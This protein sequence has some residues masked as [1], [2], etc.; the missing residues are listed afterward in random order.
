MLSQQEKV[1]FFHF[2]VGN[3]ELRL[4]EGQDFL[5]PLSKAEFS[6]GD[7][8]SREASQ[9]ICSPRPKL[10]FLWQPTRVLDETSFLG[11]TDDL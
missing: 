10:Q 4:K 7:L 8:K 11:D 9:P 5:R 3:G 1:V 2:V 6:E